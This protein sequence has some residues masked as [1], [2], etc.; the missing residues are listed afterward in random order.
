MNQEPAVGVQLF[1]KTPQPV[2]TKL[3]EGVPVFILHNWRRNG[4][5]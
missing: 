3:Q 1:F 2:Y 4:E 5:T